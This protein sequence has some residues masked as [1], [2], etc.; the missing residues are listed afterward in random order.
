MS[1]S[2]VLNE[3]ENSIFETSNIDIKESNHKINTL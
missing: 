2:G 1:K 3:K